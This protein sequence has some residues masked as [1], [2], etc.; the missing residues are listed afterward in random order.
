MGKLQASA[1]E[2]SIYL[3]A[4]ND[5]HSHT[6]THSHNQY[7]WQRKWSEVEW[8]GVWLA[9]LCCLDISG[10]F[11]LQYFIICNY[12][13]RENCFPK[14][15]YNIYPIRTIGAAH[16]AYIKNYTHTLSHCQISLESQVSSNRLD[17]I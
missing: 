3:P 16:S 11:R 2:N 10:I 4:E 14:I 8:S 9:I 1:R 5:Q 13:L 15:S 12:A 6:L 7:K 17:F